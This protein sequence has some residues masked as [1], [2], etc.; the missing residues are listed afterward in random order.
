[1]ENMAQTLGI[2][3]IT[4][5]LPD[6]T[7]KIQ[8]V[9]ICKLGESKERKIKYLNMIFQDEQEHQIKAI[10]YGDDIPVYQDIFKLFHTYLITSSRIQQSNLRF[11]KP[12]HTFSWII[13]KK[14]IIDLVDKD[15]PDEHQ[16]PPPT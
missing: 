2:Q 3:A 8:V 16:L 6:W 13:D 12:L 15:D 5:E 9:D 4:P 11:D 7:C 14:T 1:Y 10:V